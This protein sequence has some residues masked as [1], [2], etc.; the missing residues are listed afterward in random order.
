MSDPT[1]LAKVAYRA[2]GEA[3]DFKNLQGGPMPSWKGLGEQIQ[4]AWLAAAGAA[5]S[6]ALHEAVD[7][8]DPPVVYRLEVTGSMWKTGDLISE[9][10]DQLI[11]CGPGPK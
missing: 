4:G 9:I 7:R 2:Y 10:R 1:E 8:I 3:T 5:A 11:K 6:A